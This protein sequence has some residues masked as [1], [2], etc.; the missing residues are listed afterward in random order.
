MDKKAKKIIGIAG[1]IAIVIIV[2]TAAIT[3]RPSDDDYINGSNGNNIQPPPP[4]PEEPEK[5]PDL[6]VYYFYIV[7]EVPFQNTKF[8]ASLQIINNGDAPSGEYDLNMNIKDIG[9]D[10]TYHIGRFTQSPLDPGATIRAWDSHDLL[11]NDPGNFEFTIE[12][13]PFLFTDGDETNNIY[14]W[15]FMV[16]PLQP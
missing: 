6:A 12:I 11:V 2:V 4:P 8:Y 16:D 13:I 1:V 7:P 5:Q 9:R 10:L 15:P 14:S 3:L